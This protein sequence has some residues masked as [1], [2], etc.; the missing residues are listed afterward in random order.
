MPSE[1]LSNS[2]VS[3]AQGAACD[4]GRHAVLRRHDGLGAHQLRGA[5]L[6]SLLQAGRAPQRCFTA[7]R[8]PPARSF[9]A[10]NADDTRALCSYT[11]LRIA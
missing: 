5:L 3:R 6:L 11:I 2:C 7:V 1:K 4:A 9:P 8:H 10:I